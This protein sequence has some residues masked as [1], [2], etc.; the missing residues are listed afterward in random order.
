MY[1]IHI[2]VGSPMKELLIN[3]NGKENRE[4]LVY[5]YVRNKTDSGYR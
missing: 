5:M 4:W 2:F 3:K 1:N